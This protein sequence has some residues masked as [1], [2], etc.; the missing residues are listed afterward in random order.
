MNEIDKII[1]DVFEE[2]QLEKINDKLY[3]TKRQ[4]DILKRNDIEYSSK[5]I[6]QLIF[7]LED[8][9]NYEENEELDKL[10]SELAEFNYYHNTNK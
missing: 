10:S 1:Q 2:N 3:L 4:I 7:E 6:D 8:I 5:S 9:L